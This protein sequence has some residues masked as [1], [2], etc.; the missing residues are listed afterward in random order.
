MILTNQIVL[1]PEKSLI[2]RLIIVKRDFSEILE[3]WLETKPSM[4][5]I[6]QFMNGRLEQSIRG[7]L[8]MIS[9]ARKNG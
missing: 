1:G 2:T 3:E 9:G 7:D 4:E 5:Q 6:I 8:S